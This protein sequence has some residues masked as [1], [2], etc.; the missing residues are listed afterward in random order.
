MY[1]VRYKTKMENEIHIFRKIAKSGVELKIKKKKFKINYPPNVWKRFPKLLHKPFAD[2]LSYIAT[3]HL[4]LV[5]E[6]SHLTYHF[7][8]PLIEPTFFKILIYSI[9]MA[10]FEFQ[11]VLTSDL[12]KRF[13]NYN[14]KTQFKALNYIYSGK[15]IKKNLKDKAVLLFSFG[16]DSL[17]TYGLLDELG[18]AVDS[19]FMQEPQSGYE[20]AHKKKLANKFYEKIG[21]EI[22]FYPLSI[23]KLRQEKDLCWGWDIILSQYVF[24]LVPYFF[25]SQA[26][27][28]FLGNEQSCN[29]FTNDKEGYLIN[30]VYEQSVAAMQLLQDIPK[31]FFI[32]T[33]IGSLVEPVHEIFITYILHHRYPDIGKFQMSCFSE[34]LE[35]KKYRWCGKCEKCARI[36]I[37]LKALNINPE[38][39][40]FYL[41]HMLD[42]DKKDLYAIFNHVPKDSAYG[43][44][45]LG[46]D[47]QLLAFLMAYKNGVRGK[48]IDEFASLY[49]EEAEKKKDKLIKEFFGI[50]T[51]YSLPSNLRRRTLKIFGK[52]QE[53][54]SKYLNKLFFSH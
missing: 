10:V 26:K 9:P 53:T 52:E 6:N 32:N 37:F 50:H 27:Y 18:V 51:S 19:F 24:L 20:N 48:L 43:G 39:V 13:Y 31:L 42:E 5:E 34:G 4:P 41:N 28:L 35:A 3:W 30:P 14:F 15:K 8:H 38:R 21:K 1:N 36:Y 44:S 54:L 33:H 12:L 49:L 7:P 29:Y 11:N 45:G 17:L 22:E 16:K 46:R 2:S 40:G 47:E 25:S 23:G